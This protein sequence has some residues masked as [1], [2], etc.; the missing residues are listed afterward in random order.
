MTFGVLIEIMLLIFVSVSSW[1][2]KQSLE[3]RNTGKFI[4]L[5]LSTQE[6][7][8]SCLRERLDHN[9]GIEESVGI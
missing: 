6:M 5:N 9:Q 8:L 2:Y 4:A 1:L 7:I 3:M